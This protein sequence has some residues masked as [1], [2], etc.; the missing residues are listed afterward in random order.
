MSGH[1]RHAIAAGAALLAL[2]APAHASFY[3]KKHGPLPNV[4]AASQGPVSEA[5]ISTIENLGAKVPRGLT[6]VDGHT[7]RVALDDLLG[8]GMPIVL[9]LGYYKCPMLCDLVHSGIVKAAKGSGLELGR[10]FLG[11]A[12]SI[13]PNEDYKS[14]NTKQRQLLRALDHQKAEDWQFVYDRSEGAA[15]VRQLAET[16]GFK[17]KYDPQSKQFAHEAV[18]FVLTPDGTVSRYLYGVDFKPRDLRFAV[19]EA[20][21]GRVGTSLDRV[22]LACF[23]YDPFAKRYTPFAA[24]FVRI[25]AGLSCFALL[26][27]LAVLWRKEI[28]MRRRLA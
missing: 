28:S 3:G 4:S 22:L 24:A 8:R 20:G 15:V 13:D 23:R 12:V 2:A 26:A 25:G 1:T 27:L 11:L 5:D 16:L 18:A 17:Y 9:T 6:F 19:V 10:D 7:R 14:A 21:G